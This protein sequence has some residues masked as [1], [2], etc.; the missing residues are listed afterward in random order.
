VRRVWSMRGVGVATR[1]RIPPRRQPHRDIKIP[2]ERVM[3][4]ASGRSSAPKP[5]S[6]R[7][8]QRG[9]P[10]QLIYTLDSD[11]APS[12]PQLPDSGPIA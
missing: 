8:T 9:G 1:A 10:G 11:A 12:V 7:L 6:H 2:P 5:H 4:A 3:N